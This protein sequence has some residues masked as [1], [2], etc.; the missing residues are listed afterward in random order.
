MN[1]TRTY[2]AALLEQACKLGTSTLHEASGVAT[3][4]VDPAIRTVWPGASIA[5]PAYPLECSPGDNLAIHIAMERAP[6]GSV[7]VV[8]TGGFVSG[9]WGEVL[10]V[11]A[12]AAGVA[13]LIID[14][15]VRDIAAL[16]ARRFPVFTRGVSM[17]GTIKASAPS[18]G[19]PISFAGTPVAAGDLVVAD[20]D[21]VLMIPA[22]YVEATLADGQARAD[23]EAKMMDALREGRSTLELMGLTH[24][25]NGQ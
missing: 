21:G 2:D 25:R 15:G 12:E 14:G 3:S 19:Q 13:G 9:Y 1:P 4:S 17:R 8:S 18:V 20:D 16:V 22:V 5:G 11:A 10:T 23:K 24:W 6:R 7:L